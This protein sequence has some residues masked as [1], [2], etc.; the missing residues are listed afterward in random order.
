MNP[1]VEAL[2]ASLQCCFVG[3]SK[4]STFVCKEF[5]ASDVIHGACDDHGITRSDFVRF[6]EAPERVATDAEIGAFVRKVASEMGGVTH[7]STHQRCPLSL[8][9][10]GGPNAI[11][12]LRIGGGL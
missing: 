12:R 10:D 11:D 2:L 7:L 9:G 1:D 3:C 8:S 5:C 4:P 6:R